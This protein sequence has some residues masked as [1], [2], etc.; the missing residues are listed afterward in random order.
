MDEARPN[1][2]RIIDGFR[3]DTRRKLLAALVPGFLVALIGA[4]LLG[5]GVHAMHRRDPRTAHLTRYVQPVEKN[6]GPTLP[7]Q[8]LLMAG[9]LLCL[10]S[11]LVL[12]FSLRRVVDADDFLL[13]RTDGLVHQS[14]GRALLF[15][16]EEVES[17]RHDESDDSLVL[18]LVDGSEFRIE[19]HYTGLGSRELARRIADFRRK[20]LWN[21]L[22]S[23]R[24]SARG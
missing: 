13:L 19:E 10:A 7:E 18:H 20:A 23:Q 4:T 8:G 22:P 15:A 21:M 16:W 24:R 6:L 11:P 9:A 3:R 5:V 14:G 2:A 1:Q 17:I 12:A